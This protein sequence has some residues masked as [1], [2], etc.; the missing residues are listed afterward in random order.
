MS[1]L[2]TGLDYYEQDSKQILEFEYG[3]F[4]YIFKSK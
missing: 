4:A 3:E 1:L 2:E